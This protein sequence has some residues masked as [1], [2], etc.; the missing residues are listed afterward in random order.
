MREG[1]G[2]R[3]TEAETERRTKRGANICVP[4]CAERTSFQTTS[5]S[6]YK[7]CE[8]IYIYLPSTVLSQIFVNHVFTVGFEGGE[9]EREI[10]SITM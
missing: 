6:S 10:A 2:E 1:E 5:D 4:C 3:E 7:S 9:G 8:Q